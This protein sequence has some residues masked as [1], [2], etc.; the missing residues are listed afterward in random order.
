LKPPL[1]EIC[2]LFGTYITFQP[3]EAD[4]RA[5]ERIDERMKQPGWVDHTLTPNNMAFCDR[6]LPFARSLTHLDA[7]SAMVK[8]RAEFADDTNPPA[9]S[10]RARLPWPLLGLLAIGALAAL[11]WWRSA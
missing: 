1:C 11:A 8:I 10:K 6:H 2:G 3:T 9:P 5:G 4:L 7:G